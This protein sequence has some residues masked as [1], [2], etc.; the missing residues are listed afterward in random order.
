[1]P[2]NPNWPLT[3]WQANFTAG[4]YDP[5]P[6]T[7]DDLSP[8]TLG[9]TARV[10]GSTVDIGKQFELDAAE[11]GTAEIKCRNIDEWLNPANTGSPWNSSG[12]TL[13]PY[14]RIRRWAAWPL[15][16]NL[17]NAGNDQWVSARSGGTLADTASFEGSTTGTWAPVA[18]CA[19]VTD[20]T[21]THDGTRAMLVTWASTAGGLGVADVSAVSVPLKSGTTYTAS[22][23]IYLGSGPAVTLT[24]QG[25]TATST[26]TT[27]AWQRVTLTWAANGQATDLHVYA[28]GAT[29]SG[30][31][32]W[33]DSV[34]VE[35]AS[36]A[37]AFTTSGPTI[38]PVF[39]GYIERF[40]LTWTDAGK[41]GWATLTAVDALALLSRI[42]LRSCAIQDC[43]QD[44][45]VFL[46]P[47][48]DAQ[49]TVVPANVG[50]SAASA[51]QMVL[52][53]MGAPTSVTTTFG[54]STTPGVDSTSSLTFTPAD[55]GDTYVPLVDWAG[56]S[57]FTVGGAAGSTFEAWFSPTA[58][59]TARVMRILRV[60]ATSQEECA[61]Y[62]DAAGHVVFEHHTTGG[63]VDSTVS[64][65][66]TY[67][68]DGWHHVVVTASYAAGTVTEALWVDG[69]KAGS[70][71]RSAAGTMVARGAMLGFNYWTGTSAFAGSMAQF[72]VY[73]TPLPDARIQSHWLACRTGFAGDP[74]DQ[75]IRRLLAWAGWTGPVSLPK[76]AS[77]HGPLSGLGG[78][79]TSVLDA[80]KVAETTERGT[81]YAAQNGRLT[82]VP[83]GAYYQ[84]PSAMRTFGENATGGE[85]PYVA[86]AAELDPT[87]I[88]NLLT[89]TRNGGTAQIAAAAT[90]ELAYGSRTSSITTSHVNDPDA[91]SLGAYLITQYADGRL[92]VP[93]LS[94]NPAAN[95]A[96]WPVALGSK[97]GDRI[98]WKRRTS[99]GLTVVLD[100]FID[101]IS[102]SES[103]GVWEVKFT[104]SP[105]DTYQSGLIGDATYGLIGS[106][107]LATY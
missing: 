102:H 57:G 93:E 60:W 59:A 73:P 88:Y 84:Q 32:V 44:S 107:L 1:M 63:V 47:F 43:L 54:G 11:S 23:W 33:V 5:E 80:C 72:A 97:F 69:L 42:L 36:S 87:Y 31:Q 70:A 21:H 3:S 53:P 4:V 83:R 82:L 39:G 29:T 35:A 76:G 66:G 17:L 49:G 65:A 6:T 106:T 99:A 105:V 51:G 100:G 61:V 25:A 7:W 14:R 15:T 2:Q 78:G 8:D 79:S 16:G 67:L 9:P 18:G 75:R 26:T 40:P 38:Y 86:A 37:S 20:G 74:T 98:T 13:K 95:P 104:I 81:F 50:T 28:A 56:Y 101:H 68:D 55:A 58:P 45:P 85:S 46:W 71:T 19:A 52:A 91:A 41:Q 94:I 77:R 22:A 64:T 10:I 96:L 90:S 89:V 12:K 48:D 92:R 62:L 24:C 30:Q 103:P 34:Q 27:G